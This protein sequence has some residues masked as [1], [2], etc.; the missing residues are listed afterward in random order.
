MQKTILS[1]LLHLL[2]LLVVAVVAIII[3]AVA[4]QL[5]G[6]DLKAELVVVLGLV[7][8]GLAKFA[9]SSPSIPLPDYVNKPFGSKKKK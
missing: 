2:E 4:H 5:F 7:L 8:G 3:V 9:R 1:T 6:I